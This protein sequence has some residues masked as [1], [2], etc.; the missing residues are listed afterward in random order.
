MESRIYQTVI[1]VVAIF[2]LCFSRAAFSQWVSSEGIYGG[3]SRSIA[4]KNNTVYSASDNGIKI[5]SNGGVNWSTFLA[6]YTFYTVASDGISIYAGGNTNFV[7]TNQGQNWS[8]ISPTSGGV[9]FC[10][11][12]YSGKLFAGSFGGLFVS[13]NNGLN[14]VLKQSADRIWT[15]D[16]AGGIILAGGYQTGVFYSS[17]G[18][19]NW[20]VSLPGGNA[21]NIYSLKSFGTSLFA[22][23]N[24]YGV[25]K[26]TNYGI[27]WS[28]TSL[29][30]TANTFAVHNNALYAGTSDGVFTTTN[31]GLNWNLVTCSFSEQNILS[32]FSDGGNL[33]A[34][35]LYKGIFSSSDNGTSWTQGC[36]NF[37]K[38]NGICETPFGTLAVTEDIGI[39]KSTDNGSNWAYVT[40]PAPVYFY[41]LYYMSGAVYAATSYGIS[42]STNT[43]VNWTTLGP[44]YNL[45]SLYTNDGIHVIAGA[46]SNGIFVTTNSGA[47]WTQSNI[48]DKGVYCIKKYGSYFIAGGNN[49]GI[50]VSSDNGFTWSQTYSAGNCMDLD[51][52]G[53]YLVAGSS[54]G[55]CLS[56]NNG[57]N[58]NAITGSPTGIYSIAVT[59]GVIYASTGSNCYVS[60]NLGA[61]WYSINQGFGFTPYVS[62]LCISGNYLLSNPDKFSLWRR[63]LSEIQLPPPPYL[64]LPANGSTGNNLN[65]NL[66][67]SKILSAEKY[68]VVLSPDS[69]FNN[70]IMYDTL[71]TDTLKYLTGLS[72]LTKYYW[73]ARAKNSLGWG[74]YSSVF[75]FKTSG[76]A[77]QTM[78]YS[79]ANGSSGQPVSGT[80][81]WYKSSDITNYAVTRDLK[82]D[83]PVFF[84]PSA[85]T[86]YWFECGTDSLFSNVLVRDTSLTDTLKTVNGFNNITKY[87]WRVKAK[88]QVG[89]G[90]FSNVWN[91]TTIAPTPSAPTLVSPANGS[92]NISPSPLMDWLP[93]NYASYYRIQIASD[94]LFVSTVID[95]ASVTRD[96]LRVLPGLLLANNKYFWRVN[97]ANLSGT[98]VWSEI[99]SFRVNPTGLSGHFQGPPSG[100]GIDGNFPNPFN[101]ST[102]IDFRIPQDTKVSLKVY[103]ITGRE[104]KTLIN[105]EFRKADYYTVIFNAVELPGGIYFCRFVAA[106]FSKTV[107]MVLLK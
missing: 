21:A 24:I 14:W 88:N 33:F 25:W 59:N 56:S 46:L 8:A 94:S 78:L 35:T 93:V 18:G 53:G 27:N 10:L 74:A 79:P 48:T 99:W 11:F 5:S 43:G 66:A 61:T 40:T 34:G 96:S 86:G 7:S 89:W 22:G 102:K 58:W 37:S 1:L 36:Y 39:F 98:G 55:L 104:V 47:S 85:A 97:A 49:P 19:E 26:S 2:C 38:V 101:P 77:S 83:F 82:K 81:R 28:V 92:T 91:F 87:Y 100:F 44:G 57:L 69:L 107:K 31:A 80:F 65:L 3:N 23:S 75:G 60:A 30:K 16:T 106:K 45:R 4:K 105:N 32:V 29:S 12:P 52:T 13:T 15:V 63:N 71:L 6:G 72:P 64:N 73:K 76:T 84:R 50:Y 51:S 90:V 103:D 41:R 20:S 95:S 67:W 62:D 54:T 68:G 17:N 42:K 9:T 70:V